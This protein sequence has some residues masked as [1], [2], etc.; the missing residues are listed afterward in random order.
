MLE[1]R[2]REKRAEQAARERVLAQIAQDKA[3]RAA[4][5]SGSSPPAPTTQTTPVQRPVP[6]N[7]NRARLQFRLPDGSSHTHEFAS[8]EPL[9]TVR[10]YIRANLNLTFG[11]YVLSTAFPRREFTDNNNAETLADL[12]LAPNAVVL[13]LPA[14]Q[15]AVARSDGG[16]IRGLFWSMVAPFLSFFGY[17]KIFLFGTGREEVATTREP[18]RAAPDVTQASTSR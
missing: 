14:Q 11:N 9:E 5:F 15:R 10:S 18:E 17:L 6:T 16:F 3:E 2:E 4:R 1:E 12:G 7:S 8:D 13:V